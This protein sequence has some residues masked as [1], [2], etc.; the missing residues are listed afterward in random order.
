MSEVVGSGS[1]PRSSRRDFVRQSALAAGA[2]VAGSLAIARA[3][4]AAGSDVLKVGLVGCGGRGSGAAVD[5]LTADP[6]TKLVA[7]ADVFPESVRVSRENIRKLKGSQVAVDDDHCFSGLG[8]YQKVIACSD[9]VILALPTFFHPPYLKAC[10]DAGK[11]VFCEKIHAVDA[12]GV[13]LVLAAA[14]IARQ[15]GLSI[16]SGLAWRYHTG[17]QETM[18][19]VHDGAIGQLVALEETCNTGSLRCR[20]RQPGWTEMEYQIRDWYDFFWLS[21]DLPGLNLVHDLDKGAW[22][23]REEPPVRCWGMGGR[24]TRLG[25]R[26]G[27]VWDH[28]SIVYEYASGARM[29]AYCR[30][31]D[32]CASDVSDRFYGTKGRCDLLRM[33]IDGE[34][35]WRYAGPDCDRFALEHVA[36]FSAIRSGKPVNNGLYMA[37][38]SL[39]AIMATW[40]C[41]SGEVITWEQAMKSNRVVAPKRLALD[42]DPPTM[43]DAQGNYPMPVPGLTK[44]V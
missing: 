36:L 24:Q 32:G 13:R 30:Q 35:P 14:E 37:R 42:A 9:V 17:V 3:A 8:G 4:H 23:M 29:F 12:P 31:Q 21:C 11:H 27:D 41:Y 38:S 7:M 40:A 39:L 2:G 28:F 5:A 44:F 6:H 15:K 26:F 18:K 16:V 20:P 33:R 43:P 10:V 25:P 22:A 1:G 19:R 34:K